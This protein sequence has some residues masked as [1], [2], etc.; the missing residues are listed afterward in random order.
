MEQKD[1]EM[2]LALR[3]SEPSIG[4]DGFSDAIMS[5]LPRKRLSRAAARR[6]TLGGAA[7]IGSVLTS[8]LGAPLETAFSAFVLQGG[9]NPT[10]LAP[11]LLVAVLIVPIAWVISSR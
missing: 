8:I 5:S 1:A 4:D 6:W 9:F 2:E 10:I 3:A 11:V 7:A